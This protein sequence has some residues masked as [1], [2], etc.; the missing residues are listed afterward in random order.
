MS[1][2]F[3]TRD[4]DA[5]VHYI[6]VPFEP[7]TFVAVVAIAVVAM[8]PLLAMFRNAVAAAPTTTSFVCASNLVNICCHGNLPPSIIP[9]SKNSRQIRGYH[10]LMLYSVH[11]RRAS[12][13]FSN[14]SRRRSSRGPVV[15]AC[16]WWAETIG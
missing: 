11:D 10:R 7:L 13:H 3:R 14:R 15:A 8:L 12:H 1:L 9:H 5:A 6:T 4:K 2:W 16:L